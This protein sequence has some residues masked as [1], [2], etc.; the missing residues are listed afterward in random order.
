[1]EHHNLSPCLFVCLFPWASV[2]SHGCT[3]A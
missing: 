3:S 1:V 2:A